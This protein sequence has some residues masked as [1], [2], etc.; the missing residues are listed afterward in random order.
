MRDKEARYEIK[1]LKERCDSLRNDLYG[2]QR[3][4]FNIYARLALLEKHLGV[5]YQAQSTE[6][7][8]YLKV[9]SK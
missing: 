6:H 5:E 8:K 7:P 2:E 4:R 1:W 9:K 3:E